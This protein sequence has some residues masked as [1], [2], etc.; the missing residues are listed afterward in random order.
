LDKF[1]L[2]IAK[3]SIYKIKLYSCAKFTV[4]KIACYVNLA[5]CVKADVYYNLKK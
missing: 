3:I 2:S 5:I 4:C 1:G